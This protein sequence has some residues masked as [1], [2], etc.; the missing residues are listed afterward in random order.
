MTGL[1]IR[2]HREGDFTY[3]HLRSDKGIGGADDNELL[4]YWGGCVGSDVVA[5][6]QG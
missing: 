1:R 4:D 5:C 2:G 3:R 6:S